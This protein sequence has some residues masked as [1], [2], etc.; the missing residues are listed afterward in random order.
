MD[1]TTLRHQIDTAD[2]KL[3]AALAE[4]FAVVETIKNYKKKHALTTLD[5]NRYQQMMTERK[6]MAVTEGL[7]PALIET[8]FKAIH[9]HSVTCQ[10]KKD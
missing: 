9:D 2:A 4:R 10:N 6:K 7:D 1:L 8:I 3:M 5:T